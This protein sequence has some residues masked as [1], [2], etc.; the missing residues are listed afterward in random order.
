VLNPRL[1]T[2]LTEDVVPMTFFNIIGEM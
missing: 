2:N 1:I